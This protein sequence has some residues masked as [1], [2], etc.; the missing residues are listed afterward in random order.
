[1]I[2]RTITMDE[3]G[4]SIEYV[5]PAQDI[6]ANG[7]QMNHVLFIPRNDD[8]DDE[9]LDLEEKAL[10]LVRDV[11]EDVPDLPGIKNRTP[12]EDED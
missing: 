12:D 8:Y 4:V 1:L 3:T 7:V 2:I 10:Y 6:K 9:I 11:L 5:Q